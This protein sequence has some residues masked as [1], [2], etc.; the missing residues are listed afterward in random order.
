MT[1]IWIKSA[2]SMVYANAILRIYIDDDDI[3]Q[4]PLIQK[5]IQDSNIEDKVAAAEKEK[6]I[7]LSD[8]C[9]QYVRSV[10]QKQ[11]S[12]G[13]VDLQISSVSS[14]EFSEVVIDWD[15]MLAKEEV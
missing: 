2:H 4:H 13:N 1:H 11:D 15:K 8:I 14:D 6:Y 5:L 7:V 10:E 12:G 9:A 3:K